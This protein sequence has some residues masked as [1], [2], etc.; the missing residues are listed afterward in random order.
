[1]KKNLIILVGIAPNLTL[2][3]IERTRKNNCEVIVIENAKDIE[4]HKDLLLDA[5]DVVSADINN[6]ELLKREI[7]KINNKRNISGI[8]T[9]RDYYTE[10]TARVISDLGLY[11]V[12][13][14]IVYSC[15]NKLI[16]REKLNCNTNL[17]KQTRYKLCRNENDVKEFLHKIKKSI[18]IKPL[19]EK[20][21]FGVYKID[22]SNDIKK[23]YKL[24][25]SFDRDNEGILAEEFISGRELAFEVFV[26]K[27]T[28]T[29]YGISQK[30]MFKD[31]FIASGY[32]TISDL[33]IFSFK[34]YEEIMQEII[35][36]IGIDFGP[37][38]IEGFETKDKDFY[39]GEIHT[40]YAGE[41][42]FEI[43]ENA[44]N[45][46]LLTPIIKELSND[47]EEQLECPNINIFEKISG[48]RAIYNKSGIVK[49]IHGV[50]DAKKI[51]GLD[52]VE[53]FCKEGQKINELRSSLDRVGWIVAHAENK[54][55]LERIFNEAFL[56]IY[57]EMEE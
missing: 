9:F 42:I 46:D 25:C 56:K 49:K 28:A 57:I 43:T 52:S 23:Y 24:C 41:H 30:L 7:E 22:N 20:G 5:D 11:G 48:S 34:E 1:M 32:T 4:E 6:Y 54:Y 37:V 21:S 45:S 31:C 50:E 14:E 16:S 40:R 55:E 38:L 51:P 8:I 35:D 2:Q 13:P 15:N 19:K 53:I 3:F 12:S 36:K 18:V 10:T 47:S 33:N 29:L 26:S 27:G 17:I 39:F 44:S